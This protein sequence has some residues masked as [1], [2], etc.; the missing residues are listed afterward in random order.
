M[1]DELVSAADT[2]HG[3]MAVNYAFLMSLMSL[4]VEF[5]I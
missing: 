2:S 5:S 3:R 4:R 1:E